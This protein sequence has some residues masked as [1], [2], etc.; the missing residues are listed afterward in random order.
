VEVKPESHFKKPLLEGNATLQKLKSYN[1]KMQVWITNQAKFKA[2][3][4]WADARGYRFG[5]IDEN[6][7]FKSK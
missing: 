7:L 2:A 4:K 1:H 6:F 5:V 3:Q